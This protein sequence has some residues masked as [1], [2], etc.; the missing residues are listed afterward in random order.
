[1][2]EGCGTLFVFKL[3]ANKKYTTSVVMRKT[4]WK[5]RTKKCIIKINKNKRFPSVIE[6]F[7]NHCLLK[8]ITVL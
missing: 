6:N 7:Y 4:L 3:N 2:I 8:H 1:M 5:E